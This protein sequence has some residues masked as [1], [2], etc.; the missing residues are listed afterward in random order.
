MSSALLHAS[1]HPWFSGWLCILT[2]PVDYFTHSTLP[3]HDGGH[4]V[5]EAECSEFCGLSA[6]ELRRA[7]LEVKLWNRCHYSGK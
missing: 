7:T 2:N 6:R 4:I 5:A 1:S 3:Y